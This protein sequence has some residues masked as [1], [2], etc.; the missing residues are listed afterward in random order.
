[1]NHAILTDNVQVG[2]GAGA[3]GG[4]ITPTQVYG[5]FLNTNGLWLMSYAEWMKAMASLYIIFLIIS[6]LFKFYTYMR[7]KF[8]EKSIAK[9]VNQTQRSNW[10]R[11]SRKGK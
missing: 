10:K 3:A 4:V 5:D 8:S 11:L 2:L 1:M 7:G 9:D 6:I